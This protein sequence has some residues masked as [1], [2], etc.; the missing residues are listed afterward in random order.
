M[1]NA[2]HEV[3]LDDRLRIEIR[4]SDRW[5]F[6]GVFIDGNAISVDGCERASVLPDFDADVCGPLRVEVMRDG[7]CSRFLHSDLCNVVIS[8]AGHM[9]VIEPRDEDRPFITLVRGW[10]YRDLYAAMSK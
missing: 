5:T 7:D 8:E 3:S 10:D 9:A 6:S 1:T 4:F 2:T